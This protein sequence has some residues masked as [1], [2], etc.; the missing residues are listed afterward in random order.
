MK[1][2]SRSSNALQG[3]YLITNDDP[4]DVLFPKLEEAMHAGIALLQYRRK[5]ILPTDQENEALNILSLCKQYHVPL[6]IN[7]N[8]A[9]AEKLY[10]G[11]HL[12]QGDGSLI[13][14]RVRLGTDAIIGR[15]CHASLALAS[16]AVDDGASYLAFGAVF[17]SLTKPHA[18]RVDL[19][20]LSTAAER[21][22]LPICAIGGLTAENVDEV[23]SAGVNLFAVVGDV[24][25]LPVGKI[26][27]RVNQWRD[28][29]QS[30]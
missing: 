10:C 16:Q 19:E 29:L 17:P 20:T 21:F 6:I 4:F 11:V 8:I 25:N 18:N 5:K 13:D 3:L 22:P 15:T 14:A 12:G 28:T 27:E 2:N 9:L 24:L 26:A 30:V 23:R 7:D 1:N